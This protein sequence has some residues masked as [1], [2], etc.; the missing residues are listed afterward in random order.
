MK[1]RFRQ[2]RWTREEGVLEPTVFELASGRTGEY[3]G[4]FLEGDLLDEVGRP[5][6]LVPEKLLRKDLDLPR[7]S[8]PEVVRHFSRL[9]EMNYGVDSGSYWLGSCTMKYNPKIHERISSSPNV[10]R[11]HPYQPVNTV[12]GALKIMYELC[13]ML[14]KVTGLS[15]CTLQTSAGAHGEY[16]GCVI[17]RAYQEDR[18]QK[19]RTEIIIPTAAHGSNF[20]SAAMVGFKVL[21]IPT[22]ERGCTD[23]AAVKSALSEKTAGL[24]ITNPNTLG[25]FEEDIVEMAD[26][27]H[28]AGGLLYYDGANLN[29]ILGRVLL[30][31]MGVD[32]AHLNLHKTFSTP[33]GTG[34]PGGGA[35]L[36]REGLEDFLPVP[37]I[38]ERKGEYR[39]DYD[40]S[41]SIGRIRAFYGNFEVIVKAWAYLKTLGSDGLA[42][43]SGAAVLNSN[44]ALSKIRALRG[45]SLKHGRDRPR[46]HEFVVSLSGLKPELDAPALRV[47]KRLLDYGVHPPTIYFPPIVPEAFMMEPTE[48]E[49]KQDIDYY[50]DAMRAI[51][52]EVKGQPELVANAPSNL[53]IDR[54]DEV[55]A[56]RRPI[57]SWKIYEERHESGEAQQSLEQV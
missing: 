15:H 4:F 2:A 6:A 44:Y 18:G 47:A 33:H 16:L 49:S 20:A 29:A 12:Q 22:D 54:L 35:L 11:A 41:K 8:E 46:K 1:A 30:S 43:V 17:M 32:I 52:E 13:G 50:V 53:A 38:R 34:G 28:D 57:L 3:Y 21:K 45:I 24:M 31:D 14:S 48:S 27:L 51:L 5:E 25:I 56:A 42:Q 36:V 39:F 55:R 10:R 7:L 37:M 26:L 23:M 9:A 40:L 19:Q